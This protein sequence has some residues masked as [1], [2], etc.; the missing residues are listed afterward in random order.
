MAWNTR[1]TVLP[2]TL[3]ANRFV[4]QFGEVRVD[5]ENNKDVNYFLSVS[6]GNILHHWDVLVG[7]LV[8]VVRRGHSIIDQFTDNVTEGYLALRT[9]VPEY[10]AVGWALLLDELGVDS[11]LA[12]QGYQRVTELG[13]EFD[14]AAGYVNHGIGSLTALEDV[15]SNTIDDDLLRAV[16]EGQ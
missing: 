6:E 1:R 13:L 8:F 5:M 14:N 16:V 11:A 15:V 2:D 7:E 10:S 9:A 4:E 3:T 12:I